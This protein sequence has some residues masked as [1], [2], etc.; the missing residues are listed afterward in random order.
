MECTCGA[1]EIIRD[2]GGEHTEKLLEL[3]KNDL[4][5][6]MTK[7]CR[8]CYSKPDPSQV[9]DNLTEVVLAKGWVN[10]SV[11]KF[12]EEKKTDKGY[13]VNH[14]RIA[15]VYGPLASIR[16]IVKRGFNPLGQ[17][18][19]C[20]NH[21]SLPILLVDI[22][23]SVLNSAV[24]GGNDSKGMIEYLQT[25][26]KIKEIDADIDFVDDINHFLC[27]DGTIP[28]L[29]AILKDKKIVLLS[30][31]RKKREKDDRERMKRVCKF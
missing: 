20:E 13:N 25:M 23:K 2:S 8:L 27:L 21:M 22:W 17:A 29:K 31:V 16:Y 9:W 11:L 5:L 7:L 10:S 3:F 12:I 6:T 15:A 18:E 14:L 1:Y 30:K 26:V 19:F 28:E 4:T 24:L